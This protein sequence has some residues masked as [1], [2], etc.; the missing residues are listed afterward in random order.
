MRTAWVRWPTIQDQ[1]LTVRLASTLIGLALVILPTQSLDLY[2]S[3]TFACSSPPIRTLLS[4]EAPT[5]A[6]RALYH[7]SR[8]LFSS[9][10]GNWLAGSCMAIWEGRARGQKGH[11]M[12]G[13]F[14]LGVKPEGFSPS[15]LVVAYS[16]Q[17]DQSAALHFVVFQWFRG[18][19]TALAHDLH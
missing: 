7:R 1:S 3:A 5:T 4:S 6:S 8:H 13:F 15:L 10:G 14:I 17:I 19:D 2:F 9:N 11:H 16:N 12:R 18:I